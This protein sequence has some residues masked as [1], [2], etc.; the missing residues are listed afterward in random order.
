MTDPDQDE[1]VA[2]RRRAYSRDA[3]IHLDVEFNI[4]IGFDT[5]GLHG[6]NTFTDGFF[7]QDHGASGPPVIRVSAGIGVPSTMPVMPRAA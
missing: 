2:L 5:R 3:D 4:G 7:F 1:F 6:G